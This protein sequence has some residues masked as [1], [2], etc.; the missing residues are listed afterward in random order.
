ML[1]GTGMAEDRTVGVRHKVRAVA[2]MN[3]IFADFG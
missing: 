3:F 1:A 2:M